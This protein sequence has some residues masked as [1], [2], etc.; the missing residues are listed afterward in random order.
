M[1]GLWVCEG[2][3]SGT[4]HAQVPEELHKKLGTTTAP[5]VGIEAVSVLPLTFSNY[6]Q[7]TPALPEQCLLP[8]S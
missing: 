7:D 5:D 2:K 3:A 8:L 1:R 4:V 6:A